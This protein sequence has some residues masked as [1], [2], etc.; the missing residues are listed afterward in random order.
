VRELL[1]VALGGAVQMTGA[2]SKRLAESRDYNV[3]DEVQR[4][5]RE[6]T[7][8]SK[9]PVPTIPLDKPMAWEDWLAGRSTAGNEPGVAPT[10]SQRPRSSGRPPPCVNSSNGQRGLPFYRIKEL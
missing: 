10:G 6:V 3:F 9:C 1:I 7:V 8:N 4:L 5:V 2:K